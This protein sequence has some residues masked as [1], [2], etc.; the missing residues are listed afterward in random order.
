MGRDSILLDVSLPPGIPAGVPTVSSVKRT[1]PT[2]TQ[3]SVTS[4]FNDEEITA[5]TWPMQDKHVTVLELTY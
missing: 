4:K 3:R 1:F 5:R 2:D